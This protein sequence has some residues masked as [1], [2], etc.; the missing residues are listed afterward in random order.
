[1]KEFT[2]ICPVRE[3]ESLSELSKED[4]VLAEAAR[5]A[6][7]TAYAPYSR[8]CVGAALLLAD[9]EIIK[10]SNQENAAYPSGLCAERTAV[11]YAGASRP[12]VAVKK[13]A[14]AAWQD[15]GE[16]KPYEEGFVEQ[17]VSPCGGCR[18]ALAE[19]EHLYGDIEVILCGRKKFHVVPSVR[20]L[21][22]FSFVSF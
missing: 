14:V 3:Y 12:G 11:F 20:S 6:T 15:P 2:I 21:L 7:R 19:Y 18:Q 17:P 5:E 8:Y 9:G 13:I 4:R 22:P 10:G 1:M 16:G